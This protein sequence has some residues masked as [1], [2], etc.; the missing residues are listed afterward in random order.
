MRRPIHSATGTVTAVADDIL[1]GLRQRGDGVT[2]TEIRQLLGGSYQADRI[3]AALDLLRQHRLA[4]MAME[5]SGGRPAERWR[6][7][8]PKQEEQD[9]T[10]GVR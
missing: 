2:R 7:V 6:A 8:T 1:R 4:Y 10:T 9:A 5:E 3:Q